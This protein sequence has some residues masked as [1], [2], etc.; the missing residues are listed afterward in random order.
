VTA[1]RMV[2][3]ETFLNQEDN[4]SRKNR[5]V[6]TVFSC[7][8][9]ENLK[10]AIEVF[11]GEHVRLERIDLNTGRG[12][13]SLGRTSPID[14]QFKFEDSGELT[15]SLDGGAHLIFKARF[16]KLIS[17]RFIAEVEIKD[18]TNK[19]CWIGESFVDRHEGLVGNYDW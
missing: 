9:I 4:M 7:D 2:L 14:F 16:F 8:Q 13:V 10:L 3:S 5:P 6:L 15:F 11:Y 17:N 18:S 19:R 1:E 12:S